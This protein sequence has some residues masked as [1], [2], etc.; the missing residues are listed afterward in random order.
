MKSSI[1]RV[2]SAA[3]L[4]GIILIT[5][6]G[7]TGCSKSDS[8]SPSATAAPPPTKIGFLV[9]QPEEPWFQ[10]EWK[11]A[12]QAADKDGFELIKIGTPDGKKT[13]SAIDNLS[14]QGAQGFVICTPDVHLGPAIRAKADADGLKLLSVDDQFVG[15]DGKFMDDVHHLGI[16]AH[17][18]GRMVG[19]GLA[20]QMKSRGWANDDTA[21]CDITFEELDT[22]RERTDG[23]TEA[24]KEA[25]FPD[26]K[27]FKA[28]QK[29][30][31]V[32]GAIDAANI[33][34]TQHPEVK[35]WLICGMND[36][37]VMGAVR[38]ME[39][40]GFDS[41]NVCGIGINGTDCITE[42]KKDKPTGFYASIL[43]TP[44]RHGYETADMMYRWIK[45][46]T[47]PPKVT[48]TDG[49]LINRDTYQGIMKDQGLLD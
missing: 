48:Y 14:A 41:T 13:L 47:E 30:S 31:D 9:K 16:S 36:S 37:A 24:L 25:G 40:R 35:H 12:Q 18:I 29:T 4:V 22:A 43:L 45:D 42:F 7:P 26:A 6:L 27:I 10:L 1:C 23:A 28:P 3:F 20:E 19:A 46:G 34:L 5:A 44:R 8:G 15:P 32:P 49:I 2:A 33:L 38:A 21:L 11:F 17:N 39:G